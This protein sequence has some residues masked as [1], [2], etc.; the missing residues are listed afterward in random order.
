MKKWTVL[1]LSMCM[2]LSLLPV[3]AFAAEGGVEINDVNSPVVE[4][5]ETAEEFDMDQ[6]GVLRAA[7]SGVAIN[8]ANFP[9]AKFREVVEGF[10]K[11][12]DGVLSAKEIALVGGIDCSGPASGK[13]EISDLTGIEYFTSLQSL[14]CNDNQIKRLDLSKNTKLHYLNCADNQ[15]TEL[16]VSKNTEIDHLYCQNNQLTELNVSQVT[17]LHTLRCY[18]NKLTKLDLNDGLWELNC[19]KNNL[20]QLD[21]S[22]NTK[23]RELLCPN[24]PLTELDLSKNTDLVHFNCTRCQLTKLDMSK[25]TG[26]VYSY[27]DYNPL[28]ELDVSKSTA[29]KALT[30]YEC[31]LTQ[32]DVSNNPE[33]ESLYLY[34]NG[35][36]ELDVSKNT[37]LTILSCDRNHFTSLDVSNNTSLNRFSS[38]ANTYSIKTGA[39]RKFDLSQLPGSF[40]VRRAS[41]WNG[42]TVSGNILTVNAGA[43]KVTYSYDCGNGNS[44]VFTLN[45]TADD[46]AHTHAYGDWSKD[47]TNHWHECTDAHCPDKTGSVKD[48]AQHI[49]DNDAD[50]DCNVCGY[51]RTIAPTHTHTYGDWSKDA[52]N[53]WHKCT[54]VS[55]PDKSGSVKDTAQHTFEWKVDREATKTATGLKHEECTVCGYKRSENTLIGKVPSDSNTST[56]PQ[57]GDGSHIILWVI[58]LVMSGSALAVTM[59]ISRKKKTEQITIF[60]SE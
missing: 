45:V 33:L 42:G 19:K 27:C 46:A 2:A 38:I 10:D 28:V 57:T 55:C 50:T 40:D 53:H 36:T 32:L 9:D 31:P 4:T 47:A 17:K 12:Q 11:D 35:L 13:G 21:V 8:E 18:N 15:L 30:L 48:T 41:M 6:D 34:K 3:T 43:N 22:N 49:Y 52:T 16:N 24:N 44:V 25:N 29:L 58:A 56:V 7:E 54:D 26:L 5:R 60:E 14:A 39:D 51:V 1:F 37:K 59:V 23:L 20:T